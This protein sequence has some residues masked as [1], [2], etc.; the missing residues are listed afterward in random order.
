VVGADEAGADD[1]AE[2]ATAVD[3]VH[4]YEAFRF[5]GR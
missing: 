3:E 4:G 5:G 2:E 1:F